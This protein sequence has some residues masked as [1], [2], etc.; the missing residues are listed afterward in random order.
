[1]DAAAKL[2]VLAKIAGLESGG[3]SFSLACLQCGVSE[4]SVSR[5][6]AAVREGGAAALEVAPGRGAKPL[7]DLPESDAAALAAMY[8]RTNR[9]RG[10]GSAVHAARLLAQMPESPLSEPVRNAILFKGAD[11]AQGRRA[12]KHSLPAAIRRAMDVPQVH[13][14]RYRDKRA[15]Q[16]AGFYEAGR[17]RR[18]EDGSRRLYAGERFSWDDG[19]QNICLCVPWQYGGDRCSDKFGVM[20]G[21]FQFLVGVCS[22][23]NYVPGFTFVVRPEQ[24]YRACDQA[25]AVMRLFRDV[26]APESLVLEGGWDSNPRLQELCAMTS[27]R[28]LSARGRPQQKLVENWWSQAWTDMSVQRGHV[29]RYRG[30]HRET[31]QLYLRCRQGIEDPR[32]HFMMIGEFMDMLQAAIDYRNREPIESRE[33]GNWVPAERWAEDLADHPRAALSRDVAHLAAPVAAERKVARGMVGVRALSPAG[34]PHMYR[35]AGGGTYRAEGR[36]VRVYFDPWE[37]IPM[38]TIVANEDFAGVRKGDVLDAQADC[39]SAAPVATRDERGH[40]NVLL[41]AADAARQVRRVQSQS[42]RTEYRAL[43][44]DG[45][46]I[47]ETIVR[48]QGGVTQ[49]RERGKAGARRRSAP[50]APRAKE[51]RGPEVPAWTEDPAGGPEKIATLLELAAR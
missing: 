22:A 6:R 30:E 2:K 16:L 37:Q 20:V 24:S 36:Q 4:S 42:A 17:L 1:M 21:R 5:W 40:W 26:C 48:D 15:A 31:T 46:R 3:M 50:A 45:E 12:S 23:S 38:A 35:F 9:A 18:L 13:V 44:Q 49:H 51:S 28:I 33:Y 25:G 7:V 34:A 32:N 47:M 19:T 14:A 29:G 27:T 39:V 41:A 8:I 11:P 43:T 10:Q